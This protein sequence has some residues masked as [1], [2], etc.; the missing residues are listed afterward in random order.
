LTVIRARTNTSYA[1]ASPHL[2]V[3]GFIPDILHTH[4]F[5]GLGL[6]NFAVYYEFVTGRPDF[7]PHSFYVSQIV[8]SGIVGTALFAV[9]VLWIF[10]RLGVARRIG[11]SLSA[12]GDPLATHVRPLAWGMTAALV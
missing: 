2:S 9:F 11:R 3:Y 8:E 10:K 4:P 5:F 12:V 6:N 7:G 1:A